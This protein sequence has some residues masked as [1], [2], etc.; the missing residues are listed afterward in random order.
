MTGDDPSGMTGKLFEYLFAKKPILNLGGN[1]VAAKIINETDSGKT[2]HPEEVKE[3]HQFINDV[4]NN[5]ITFSHRN[6]SQYTRREQCKRLAQHLD[7]LN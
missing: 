4:K 1:N 5:Q 3:V 7:Q 6:L 2:I